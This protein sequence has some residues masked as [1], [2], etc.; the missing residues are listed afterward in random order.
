MPADPWRAVIVEDDEAVAA[1]HCRLVAKQ[2]GFQVVGRAET[3]S[4]GLRLV[5]TAQPHLVLLD[6]ELPGPSGLAFLRQIRLEKR[7]V[8]AIVISAHARAEVVR[9]S[10]QL[11]AIDYLVKPFWPERLIGALATFVARMTSLR[12]NPALDQDA[13]DRMRSGGE[14]AGSA[15]VANVRMD[16]LAEVR[17]ALEGAPPM[18]ADELAQRTGMARVTARRYL[19]HLVSRGQCTVDSVSTGPGRPRKTYRLWAEGPVGRRR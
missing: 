17:R 18:T 2:P 7:P 3:A 15:A 11:G 13:I 6:L 8:E 19:E 5:S 12:D 9:T 4:G 10:M 14:A 1:V 16:R